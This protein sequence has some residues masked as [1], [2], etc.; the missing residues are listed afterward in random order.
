MIHPGIAAG[1]VILTL[2]ILF[3][4]VSC[5]AHAVRI[6]RDIANAEPRWPR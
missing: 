3:V 6:G 4:V 5:I 2:A 1:L